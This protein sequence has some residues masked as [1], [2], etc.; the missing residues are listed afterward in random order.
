LNGREEDIRTARSNEQVAYQHRTQNNNKVLAALNEVL[1]RLAQAVFEEQ[2]KQGAVL[3][4]T[5]R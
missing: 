3:L 1:N 4:E 2:D 5:E